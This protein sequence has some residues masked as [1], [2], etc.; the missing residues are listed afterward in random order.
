MNGCHQSTTP[1]L[2]RFR[3]Q[4]L[5]LHRIKRKFSL[6]IW[7]RNQSRPI[8]IKPKREQVTDAIQPLTLVVVKQLRIT[9][10]LIW[11]WTTRRGNQLNVLRRV[12]ITLRR[13]ESQHR[14]RPEFDA[15][16]ITRSGNCHH[17]VGKS[18]AFANVRPP[19]VTGQ[20]IRFA[21]GS[22][23]HG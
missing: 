10:S 12:A 3:P 18:N 7:P 11:L 23:R 14:V 9:G 15:D 19:V 1:R 6:L 22:S 13:R 17:R 2:L 8:Q 16:A 20:G 21:D 5:T 4:T